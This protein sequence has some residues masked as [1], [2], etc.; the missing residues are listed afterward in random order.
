MRNEKNF[1]RTQ[2]SLNVN[3]SKSPDVWKNLSDQVVS[4]FIF[5]PDWPRECYK[6]TRPITERCETKPKL[7]P[8]NKADA[9]TMQA[10]WL[11]EYLIYK[12]N[13]TY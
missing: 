2:R 11:G 12:V 8:A 7:L 13:F 4:K 3:T 1:I 5:A 10:D 6:F 9:D